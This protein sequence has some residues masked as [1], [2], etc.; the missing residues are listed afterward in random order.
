MLYKKT[1][2][3]KYLKELNLSEAQEE[4]LVGALTFIAERILDKKYLL[5]EGKYG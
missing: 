3:Q 5:N 2:Y 4:Q 1:E